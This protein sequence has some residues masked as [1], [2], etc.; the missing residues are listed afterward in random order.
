[1]NDKKQTQLEE[2][3]LLESLYEFVIPKFREAHDIMVSML[4]FPREERIRV[5]ELGCGFGE[6]SR[7]IFE[8]FPEAVIMGL[9][10]RTEILDRALAN[11][12][13]FK[14]QFIPMHKDLN[15]PQWCSNLGPLHAVMSSFTLDYLETDRHRDLISEAIEEL[16]TDGRWISC[17]F[18]STENNRINRVFHDIE[19][20]IIQ[21]AMVQGKVSKEQIESLT[22]SNILRQQHYVCE[23]EEKIEWLKSA[24]FEEIEMPWRFLNIAILTAKKGNN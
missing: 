1:M 5:A 20:N 11:L 22:E 3:D 21:N 13:D 24:G 8:F 12:Q 17:E 16:D 18:F 10:N 23:I 7:R 15:D 2:I 19:V 9:D 6:L 14:G 4:D